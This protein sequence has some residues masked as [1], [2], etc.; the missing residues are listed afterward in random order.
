VFL[1]HLTRLIAHGDRE[2]L[3]DEEVLTSIGLEVPPIVAFVDAC[4]KKNHDIN[5]YVNIQDLI[6]GVYND[7]F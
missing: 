7:V 3:R 2:L 1:L 6:K 5:Y 4:H